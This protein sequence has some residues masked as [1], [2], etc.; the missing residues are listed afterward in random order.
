MLREVKLTTLRVSKSIGIYSIV[1]K[2]RWRR[3]RL[4][5]LCF[6]GIALDDEHVWSSLYVSSEHLR[7]RFLFMKENNYNVL[8]LDA[9]L[10]L[11]NDGQLP[12]KSVA[13]TLDDGFYDFF[14]IGAAGSSGVCNSCLQYG[15]RRLKPQRLPWTLVQA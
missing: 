1:S 4:L 7:N 6:H 5:I 10:R 8:S 11:L 2:N 15:R 12:P 14:K 3:N 9:G 13:I